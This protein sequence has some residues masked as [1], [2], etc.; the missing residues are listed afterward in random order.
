M[1]QAQSVA[2]RIEA[3]FPDFDPPSWFLPA[4]ESH[5]GTDHLWLAAALA[6]ARGKIPLEWCYEAPGRRDP[7]SGI[8]SP[9]GD[10]LFE[11]VVNFIPPDGGE[12]PYYVP[13]L[14]PICMRANPYRL[15]SKDRHNLALGAGGGKKEI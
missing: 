6:F 5:A 15:V 8:I 9:R 7:V 10:Q 1:P 4:Y 11:A 14:E 13:D 2:S 3:L 12:N